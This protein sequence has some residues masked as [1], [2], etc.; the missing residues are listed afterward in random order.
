MAGSRQRELA[1]QRRPRGL[2][3]EQRLKLWSV[4]LR[5]LYVF[6]YVEWTAGAKLPLR[7]RLRAW[8]KGFLSSSWLLYDLDHNDPTLY[9]QDH[10]THDYAL[11]DRHRR[12]IMDKL[13]FTYMMRALG[14]PHP[15]PRAFVH[16]GRLLSLDQNLEPSGPVTIEQLLL[17]AS[18][19]VFRPVSGWGGRGV[20]FVHGEQGELLVDHE[21]CEPEEIAQRV[22]RLDQYM[23]TDYLKPADYSLAIH[24]SGPCTVRIL[25]NWDL[26][27][28]KPFIAAASHR[29][30]AAGRMLDAFKVGN[31]SLVS[32]I[33]YDTGR[34][35]F[36]RNLDADGKLLSLTHHPESGAPIEGV[37]VPHWEATKE[38]VLEIAA[39]LPHYPLVGWDILVTDEGPFWLEGNSPPGIQLW[40]VHTPLLK[41]PRSRAFYEWLGA[42]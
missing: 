14:V 31:S 11:L 40:Q 13:A 28:N 26:E 10:R 3:V 42:A 27:R 24:P 15:T 19:L 22:G 38:K 5:R 29:F 2:D 20:F 41:D 21:P 7:K 36:G 37:T 32:E 9:L 12:S 23:V 1:R 25:T 16:Q 8:R 33:D 30:G 18:G 34:L 35:G 4:G 17:Q 39:A 6:L